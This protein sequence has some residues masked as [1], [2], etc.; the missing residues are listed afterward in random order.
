[1]RNILKTTA[2]LVALAAGASAAHAQ[3][4]ADASASET[5]VVTATRTAQSIDDV[6]AT[7]SV[8]DDAEIENNLVNDVKDLIR[9]EPGVSVQS[10]PARFTAAGSGTG[11]AA[12]AGF[13]IRGLDG[14][15]VLIQVDGVRVPDAYSFS[16]VNFGRGDYVDVDTLRSVEIL[17]GPASA[18]Y[19]SDGLAGAVSFITRD[20]LDLLDGDD[21]TFAARARV[22]YA[23]ADASTGVSLTGATRAGAWSALLSLTRR[24]GSE[25]ENQGENESTSIARTAPNP[26]DWESNAALG[27]IVFEPSEHHRFRLTADYAD[28]ES[29]ADILSERGRVTT[30]VRNDVT[31]GIDTSERSRIA[32]DHIYQ[33]DG[34]L[35]DSAQWNV[36]YQVSEA[37]QHTLERRTTV[38]SGL[39]NNRTRTST[40]DN[41]VWGAAVQLESAFQTGSVGHRF[42]YGADYS[43]T[44]QEGLRDG[45]PDTATDDFPVRPFP[46][47]D[48]TLA[49][50][51]IQDEISILDGQLL[52]YPALRYDSYELD[53][54][55][56]ALYLAA[57]AGQSDSHVSPKFGVVV[58]PIDTFGVYFNY[59]AGF[60]APAAGQVNEFFQNFAGAFQ[61]TV[62]PNP[63]LRPETSDSVEVGVRWR[64]VNVAGATWRANFTAYAGQYEDFIERLQV[65]GTGAAGNPIRYQ[66]VNLSEVQITGLEGR[67]SGDW[68]NGFGF[69]LAASVTEGEYEDNPSLPGATRGPLNSVD[70]FKVVAG[71]SYS[72]PSNR[73]GGQLIAT[74]V[75]EKDP[76]DIDGAFLATDSFTVLDATAFWALTDAA[77][78]RLGVFNITDESYIHWADVNSLTM[79]A[80]QAPAFTQ[81]GRNFSV[82]I[83]YRF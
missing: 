78:L 75:G 58:W 17:R 49:G 47:T 64:D 67:I 77:T 53:P 20:P 69:N 83:G 14:N 66:Y 59:A 55:R 50:A 39:A 24:D 51:F 40:F 63:N 15:R 41:E 19:G 37:W 68:G 22:G 30:G 7:V 45:A 42:V 26:Q 27:R 56:D 57:P 81:P 28:R 11:R 70:P 73:Y 79:T 61:Y 34:G 12:N 2:A 43:H 52:L 46:N 33:N 72:A 8:V 9:F 35:I 29:S 31:T 18:L 82:S 6:P 25:T 3:Q 4:F 10:Q 76:S 80:A 1:M 21:D 13:N 60:K 65:G 32:F 48:Y 36:Y 71:V 16:A 23:S 62:V 74:Y 44:Y 54:Q 38:A 5:I